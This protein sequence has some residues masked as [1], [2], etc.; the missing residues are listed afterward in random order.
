MDDPS[1]G[2]PLKELAAELD[3]SPSP[4]LSARVR[5]QVEAEPGLARRWHPW[6]VGSVAAGL[7]IVAMS[8]ASLYRTS[9]KPPASRAAVRQVERPSVPV[10]R[11]P[12]SPGPAV[13]GQPMPSGVQRVADAD[14]A[15]TPAIVRHG[16]VLVPP[17]QAIALGMLLGGIR[18]GR[19]NVPRETR[20]PVDADGL[21]LAPEPIRIPLIHIEPIPAL[22]DDN[23]QER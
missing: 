20:A 15:S 8:G 23:S 9:L 14:H 6:A 21:L 11:E 4:G 1:A 18:S 3:I 19:V 17:D 5:A 16:D 22:L 2:D 10:P 13:Q 7:A 12:V